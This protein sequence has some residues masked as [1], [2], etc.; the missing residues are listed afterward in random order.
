MWAAWSGVACP[1]LLSMQEIQT[2]GWKQTAHWKKKW[3][4]KIFHVNKDQSICN[5][6]PQILSVYG[7]SWRLDSHGRELVRCTEHT[8][9]SVQLGLGDPWAPRGLERGEVLDLPL[10]IWSLPVKRNDTTTQTFWTDPVQPLACWLNLK[11]HTAFAASITSYKGLWIG[12]LGC[13]FKQWAL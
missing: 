8:E 10:D 12:G 5:M 1:L 11:N 6:V 4:E 3:K 7:F 2:V 13:L 9:G